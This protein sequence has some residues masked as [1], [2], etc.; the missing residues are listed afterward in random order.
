MLRTSLSKAGGASLIPGW[1]AEIPHALGLKN[2]NIKKKKATLKEIQKLKKV[3]NIYIYLL[4]KLNIMLNK[5]EEPE[6][7]GEI[8]FLNSLLSLNSLMY[9]LIS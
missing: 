2:Q 3:L 7:Y 5:M 1:G 4:S 6:F 9:I 8:Y